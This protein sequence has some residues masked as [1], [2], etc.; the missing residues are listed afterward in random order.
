MKVL[1]LFFVLIAFSPICLAQGQANSDSGKTSL[2]CSVV[3]KTTRLVDLNNKD[4]QEFSGAQQPLPQREFELS[5]GTSDGRSY[6]AYFTKDDGN[7]T[8]QADAIFEEY[9]K[10]SDQGKQTSTFSKVKMNLNITKDNSFTSSSSYAEIDWG[11]ASV[12]SVGLNYD[13]KAT[14]VINGEPIIGAKLN[15]YAT[16]P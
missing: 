8:F 11:N 6:G 13:G 5:S 4:R 7:F 1:N 15:C 10:F 16:R 12:A 9:T 3:Y 2:N 14:V